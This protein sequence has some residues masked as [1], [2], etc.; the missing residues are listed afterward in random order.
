MNSGTMSLDE[1]GPKGGMSSDE[2][3]IK[4]ASGGMSS[5]E[6]GPKGAIISQMKKR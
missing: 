2:K 3:E 5:D 6:N 1:N 4:S